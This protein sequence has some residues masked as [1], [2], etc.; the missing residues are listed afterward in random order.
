MSKPKCKTCGGSGWIENEDHD[1]DDPDDE[2]LEPEWILCP[3]C[4]EETT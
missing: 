1:P 4:N 2:Y 3:D